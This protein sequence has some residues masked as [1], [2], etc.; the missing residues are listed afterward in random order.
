MA[1]A[2]GYFFSFNLTLS[3]SATFLAVYA[4]SADI[5]RVGR[6]SYTYEVA[7]IFNLLLYLFL[8]VA[9]YKYGRKQKSNNTTKER[10]EQ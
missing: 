2:P 8:F 4:I 7:V 9:W 1:Y 6:E 3:I 5:P 10:G